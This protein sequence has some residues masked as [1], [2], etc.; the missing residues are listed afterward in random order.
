[1]AALD[2]KLNVARDETNSTKSSS[3]DTFSGNDGGE[4]DKAVLDSSTPEMS[5]DDY[6]HGIKLVLLSAA[7]LVS[8][9]LIALD[10]VSLPVH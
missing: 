2:E 6:P 4:V 10:Q 5:D 9:F 7:S 1:M 3:S 8:V